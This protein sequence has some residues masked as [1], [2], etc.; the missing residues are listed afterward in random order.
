MFY[1]EN[2]MLT[3]SNWENELKED[4]IEECLKHGELLNCFVETRKTGGFVYLKFSN[5]SGPTNAANSL[6]GR[7]F[8]G[9]MI[10]VLY[11]EENQFQSLII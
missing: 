5:I 9:R 7:Y 2:E 10:S 11:L 3:N 6:H 8:A 1:I 4:M